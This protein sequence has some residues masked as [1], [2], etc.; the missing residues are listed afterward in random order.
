MNVSN[1]CREAYHR[2]DDEEPNAPNALLV[3]C[4]MLLPVNALV[5]RSLYEKVGYFEE[6]IRAAP[7]HDMLLRL[8]KNTEFA[9][10]PDHLFLYR[11]HEN[12]ISGKNQDLRW[13]TGFEI[14][15]RAPSRYPYRLSTV[16]KRFAVLNS[17]L[18]QV[19][20]RSQ[21]PIQAVPRLLAAGALDPVRAL[22]VIFRRELVI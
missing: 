1:L 2:D 18:A 9:D 16:R 6:A 4:Y 17:R 8:A 10:L 5:R 7:D 20:L 14:L 13:R 22:L 15:R 11:M 12:S 3:D 21:R 19:A